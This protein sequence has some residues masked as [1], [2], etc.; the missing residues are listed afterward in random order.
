M[1][2]IQYVY[3]L[4]NATEI[5]LKN[6]VISIIFFS[7]A[8]SFCDSPRRTDRPRSFPAVGRYKT[9]LNCVLTNVTSLQHFIRF[10]IFVFVL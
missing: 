7:L 8:V 5:F 6:L 2:T 1:S 3:T 4:F 9:Y 10:T